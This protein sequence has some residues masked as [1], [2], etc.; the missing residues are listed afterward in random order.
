MIEQLNWTELTEVIHFG[1]WGIRLAEETSLRKKKK[2]EGEGWKG[3]KGLRRGRY[4]K[5]PSEARREGGEKVTT[6]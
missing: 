3:K 6:S 4:R 2:K 5:G 1:G